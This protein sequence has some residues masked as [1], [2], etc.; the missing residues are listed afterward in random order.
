MKTI[1]T[2]FDEIQ[3]VKG[4]AN[5]QKTIRVPEE[6]Q[7]KQRPPVIP[8]AQSGHGIQ[9]PFNIRVQYN[10]KTILKKETIQI[11]KII[12]TTTKAHLID[13][14]FRPARQFVNKRFRKVWKW[15]QNNPNNDEHIIYPTNII[16]AKIKEDEYY[17]V[18]GLR[19]VI[20]LKYSNFKTVSVLV[21]DYRDIYNKRLSVN[22]NL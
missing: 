17:V 20:A 14:E 7:T 21:I 22:F 15:I 16:L 13:S 6:E 3:T 12:G 9:P 18:N 10:D 1:K 5:L 2:E 8:V 4:I 11:S 19:R